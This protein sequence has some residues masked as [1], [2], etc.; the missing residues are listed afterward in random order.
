MCVVVQLMLKKRSLFGIAVGTSLVLA[1][2]LSDDSA[3]SAA[4]QWRLEAEVD[5]FLAVE[6]DDVGWNIDDLLSHSDVSLSDEDSSVV[7]GLGETE[8]EH[9]GLK[10]SLHEVLDFQTENVVELHVLL[11]ENTDSHQ[12]SKKSVTLE[13]SL[14]VLV[15]E[16]EQV[17]GSLSDLGQEKLDPPDLF[18]VLEAELTDELQ[19]GVESLLLVRSLWGDIRLVVVLNVNGRHDRFTLVLFL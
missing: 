6:S 19:L 18:L 11:I 5:V 3:W 2:V 10:S 7:D 1:L 8:L 16:S 4:G 15:L 12:S 17:S 13:Q 14:W 9:L